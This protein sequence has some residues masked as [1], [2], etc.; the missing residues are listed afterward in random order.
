ML[1]LSY[2]CHMSFPVRLY[3]TDE[4]FPVRREEIAIWPEVN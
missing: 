2:R 4:S 3:P 1:M